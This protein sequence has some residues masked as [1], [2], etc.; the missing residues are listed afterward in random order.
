MKNQSGM[1]NFKCIHQLNSQFFDK[2]GE[3]RVDQESGWNG[4]GATDKEVP[5]PEF[6]KCRRQRLVRPQNAKAHDGCRKHGYQQG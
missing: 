6:W 5:Y 2:A 3:N 4:N 1:T